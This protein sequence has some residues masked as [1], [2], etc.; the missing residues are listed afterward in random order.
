MSASNIVFIDCRFEAARGMQFYKAEYGGGARPNA[1]INCVV[2]V[3][4]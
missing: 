3:T 2:P 4:S 1:L